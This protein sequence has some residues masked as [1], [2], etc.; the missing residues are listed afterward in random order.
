MN[1]PKR[2]NS[3]YCSKKTN[4]NKRIKLHS[5]GNNLKNTIDSLL[6]EAQ[7]QEKL[8]HLILNQQYSSNPNIDLPIIVP[9]INPDNLPKIDIEKTNKMNQDNENV[10]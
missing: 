3:N 9:K 5:L 2:N 10:K 6:N 4:I 1:R 7:A 8:D